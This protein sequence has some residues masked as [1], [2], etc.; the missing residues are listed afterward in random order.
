MAQYN[1]LYL[2]DNGRQYNVGL[3][4]G[5]RTGHI[6]VMCNARVVL[7]DFSVKEA[8]DY[9]FFIDDELFELSI[10]GGPGRY[11][12][13][14]AINEDADTPRNRDRKKQ[15]RT[16]FR[17]TVA[18]ITIF[19]LVV[20]GALGFAA[21]NQLETPA[22]AP[23]LTLAE[24][25]METTARIFIERKGEEAQTHIKYSFVADGRVREYRQQLDSDLIN[26]FPL[27]DGDEFVIRY[28]HSRPSV[29]ELELDQPTSRQ[30][31]RYLKRTLHQHQELN[32]NLT[33]I[34]AKCRVDIAYRLGGVEALAVLF[35]QQTPEK[36][37]LIFNEI[38]YKKFVRDIPF[39][40]AVEKECW[41]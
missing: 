26:G 25:S 13:N 41:N 10:E 2:G 5:D 20:I 16:D 37:H 4:H 35:N 6:M 22:H 34:Q 14:C 33:R 27:E 24:N 3:F 31:E 29:H 17:K 28:V 8:K 38:T 1:W 32:P 12:Y 36:D 15:K 39:L 7:I 21:V 23:P 19:A 9:S 11:A 30:L 18:L 40:E